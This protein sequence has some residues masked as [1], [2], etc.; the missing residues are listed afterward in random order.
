MAAD[1]EGFWN[2][3]ILGWEDKKYKLRRNSIA[4]WSD[5]NSS[6]KFRMKVATEVLQK[7]A[8]DRT[9]VEWGC[10]SAL[11]MK[12]ILA[13]GAKK[14]IGIDISP[15]AIERARLRAHELG[16]FSDRVELICGDVR[17]LEK[18]NADVCVSLGLLDWLKPEEIIKV[19]KQC[20]AEFFL[21]SF[22]EKR[23]SVAQALHTG[24]VFFLYGHKDWTY[25]PQ[26]Y[27]A[28]AMAGWFAQAGLVQ[29]SFYRHRALSFGCLAYHL[30]FNLEKEFAVD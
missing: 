6:V 28:A 13:A 10:G 4:R 19:L 3:K 9:I 26:Y 29:P 22:S 11:M 8:K 18:I 24:Y 15:V 16:D 2:R 23:A 12:Q 7:V 1:A 21:H 20:E 30:P 27:G 25:T 14:Y 17:G 5:V